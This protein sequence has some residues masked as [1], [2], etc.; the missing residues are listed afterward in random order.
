M[1]ENTIDVVPITLSQHVVR[2]AKAR[3][4]LDEGSGADMNEAGEW[5]RLGALTLSD[6][7]LLA[8]MDEKSVRNAANPK[9]KNYLKTF[10]HGARTYVDVDD[11]K[12]WLQHRRGFKPTV[13]VD[14]LAERDL[15][16]TGFFSEQDFSSYLVAQRRK[17]AFL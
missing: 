7:A 11:A 4:I 10:N 3:W 14:K 5:S 2:V 12:A 16:K 6:V 9:H 13:I 1:Y 15:T 8:N 17:K